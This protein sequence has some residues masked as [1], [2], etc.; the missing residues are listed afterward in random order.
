MS[1]NNTI[2]LTIDDREVTVPAG[3][4][5]AS[6]AKRVGIEIP[7]FCYH[8]K[9]KP[10]GMCRMCL[11]EI[12]TPRTNRET[13]ETELVWWGKLQTACTTEVSEGMAVRTTS[14][15]V[16]EAQRGIIEFLLTS[17]PLDCPI[18]DKGGECPL[19]NL[20]L[21]HGVGSSRFYLEDKQHLGKRVPLGELIFLDQERCILCGRCIRFCNEVADDP[22][23][24]FH[25]RGRHTYIV[26]MSEPG[27]DSPFSGDTTDICPVGALTTADFRFGARPWEM[28]PVA[29]VCTHCPVG[30]NMV[31]DVRLDRKAGREVIKRV[32]PRQ[33]E[34]VNEIWICDKGR[35]GHHFAEHPERLLHPKL[36][37]RGE[38]VNVT[39]GEALNA[40]IAQL[41]SSGADVAGIAGGRLSNEDLFAFRRLLGGLGSERITCYPANVGGGD[42]IAQV[43]VGVGTDFAAMGPETAI[44]VVA[45]DLH[46]EVPIWWLRIKQA[47]ERGAKLIVVN[48]RRT[49][50]DLFATHVI[51]YANGD[52]AAT[53]SA[54]LGAVTPNPGRPVEGLD[55]T[56]AAAI[57]FQADEHLEAATRAFAEAENAV[58]IVGSEGLAL[59][60][61]QA[62]A[63]AA[64]N[65]LVATGHVG[66]PNN[67]LM[68]VWP[69]ANTQAAI[70][71]D[72]AGY[73][74]ILRAAPEGH[75]RTLV[76]A[77]ADPAFDDPM[78]GAA[79]RDTRAYTVVL[80][81]F[82]TETAK[83]ADAVLPIQSVAERG[84]TYTNGER[85]VQRFYPAIPVLG[86]ARPDWAVFEALREA[87][88]LG[89]AS[90]SAAAL[91]AEMAESAP[92]Y[93][94][95]SY[96]RLAEVEEQ[97]PPVGGEDI[98]YSGTAAR[99][100]SGTGVQW[101]SAAEDPAVVLHMAPPEVGE[102]LVAEGDRL[103]VVPIRLLYDREAAFGKTVLLYGRV[104][105]PHVLL[106]VAD[107]E[108]LGLRD[109][110]VVS[111]GFEGESVLVM[112]VVGEKAPPGVA[113]LPIRLQPGA[114]PG[115]AF[116]A[117]LTK[118]E[119]SPA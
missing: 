24:A 54:M 29:T 77:G 35:L 104:P 49:R 96:T 13:G 4:V 1:D 20:T 50:L 103:V 23:I 38:L 114:S 34:R 11:V 46:Q 5:I 76:I 53:L 28:T 56:M 95:L 58:V 57:G 67:G 68:I 15:A 106:N 7:V 43:G 87:L 75:I 109:G 116:V 51:R 83:L 73:A 16:R 61:S 55:E 111:L 36:R 80:D 105:K 41:E 99:N 107:A 60:E 48:G 27:F 62:L 89:R 71:L 42:L 52:E 64:A 85:R 115:A 101:P 84:G 30:C 108:R 86:E 59:P 82:L 93:A 78:A 74:E 26:T 14:E 31:F 81:M 112:A 32:R 100:T 88:K 97:W 9:L 79:L 40:V 2:T 22:V 91:M 102:R 44:L 45:S 37:K 33:N 92:Q 94:G 90:T 12:G 117:T 118:V 70:E 19:Q 25:E 3:T 10:A 63:L 66:R 113:L 17:H 65:L 119:V 18:C 47:A 21:R 39:W 6:A 98:Y 72:G 69:G 8:P 110:D